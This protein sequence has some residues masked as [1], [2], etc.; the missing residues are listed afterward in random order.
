MRKLNIFLVAGMMVT[1]IIHAI[2]ASGTLLGSNAVNN[3]V[4]ARAS[5]GFAAAHMVVGTVL[6]IRTLKSLKS[7]AR[8]GRKVSYFKENKL[9]WTRRISGFAIIIPLVMHLF[10][11]TSPSGNT[12]AYRLNV[13]TTGRMISQIL[14][15]ITLAV[16]IITNVK[17]VLIT[18]GIKRLKPYSTDI[19][20]VISVLLL[21]FAVAFLVYYIRWRSF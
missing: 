18:F 11:F 12:D 20:L 8:D 6:T 10:I 4:I 13:F 19:I 15:V 14:L 2:T 17:P 16:H 7:A 5:A 21:I 1:F 3:K 9:F